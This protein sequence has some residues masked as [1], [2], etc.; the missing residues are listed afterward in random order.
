MKKNIFDLGN[1][2]KLID[3]YDLDFPYRTG[4]YVF[5]EDEITLIETGPSK[6]I[7]HVK[8]GLEQ[9]NIDLSDIKHIIVTHIHLD[10]AGGLGLLLEDCPNAVCYVHPRGARHLID[11]SRLIQ[12]ARAVYGDEF[13]KMYSPIIP[14]PEN[15][16]II[17]EDGDTLTIGKNRT[18]TFYH[19]KGHS[20]HHFS[21][22]DS[23]S[24]GIFTGD[25]IGVSYDE[26]LKDFNVNIYIPSTSPNQFRPRDMLESLERIKNMQVDAIYFGHFG[27]V[28]DVEE[29]YKQIQYWLPIFMELGEQAYNEGRDYRWLGQKMYEKIQSVL[30][31]KGVLDSH[32]VY[33]FVEM[34]CLVGAMGII[35]YLSKQKGTV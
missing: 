32:P 31:E 6:S 10:H 20:D 5:L 13:D 3:G 2:I 21:I 19:T 35:D 11:P 30:R 14:V 15:K 4:T 23:L 17:K 26:V 27:A 25:T 9:L 12:G 24:N 34:D 22:H 33:K 29:V 8:K 7:P 1:N 18:L 28:R 16:V